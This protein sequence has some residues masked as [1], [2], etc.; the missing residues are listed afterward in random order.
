M[1]SALYSF[2]S[3][4]VSYSKTHLLAKLCSSFYYTSQLVNK[5]R[6]R[7]FHDYNDYNDLTD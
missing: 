3:L 4:V 7:A 2:Y 6:T 5:N 1:E